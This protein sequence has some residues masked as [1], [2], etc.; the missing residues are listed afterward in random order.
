MEL[1]DISQWVQKLRGEKCDH[2][3]KQSSGNA[4]RR[5]SPFVN[6]AHRSQ[7]PDFSFD[8]CPCKVARLKVRLK[9]RAEFI[10]ESIRHEKYYGLAL[11]Y[12]YIDR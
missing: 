5:S 11:W 6:H 7:G 2:A 12:V 8:V 3:R 4:A 1:V 10:T 9:Q